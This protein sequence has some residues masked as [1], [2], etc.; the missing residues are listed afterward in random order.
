VNKHNENLTNKYNHN[1]PFI[2]GRK[3]KGTAQEITGP[4]VK[5]AEIMTNNALILGATKR[6]ISTNYKPTEMCYISQRNKCVLKTTG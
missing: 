2:L 6:E 1:E 5:Y 4:Y 3:P